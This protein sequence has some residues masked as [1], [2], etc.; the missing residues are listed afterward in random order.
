MTDDEWYEKMSEYEEELSVKGRD[1]APPPGSPLP[2]VSMITEVDVSSAPMQSLSTSSLPSVSLKAG[3]DSSSHLHQSMRSPLPIKTQY[4]L[5]GTRASQNRLIVAVKDLETAV[6]KSTG[7]WELIPSSDLSLREASLLQ[8]F[9]KELQ[10]FTSL[11]SRLISWGLAQDDQ[12]VED[13]TEA[14]AICRTQ[15]LR[16][17]RFLEPIISNAEHLQK[18]ARR[19]RAGL[20]QLFSRQNFSDSFEVANH[21]TNSNFFDVAKGEDILK[22]LTHS[23]GVINGLL[24]RTRSISGS[25]SRPPEPFDALPDADFGEPFQVKWSSSMESGNEHEV[26]NLQPLENDFL[27]AIRMSDHNRMIALLENGINIDAKLSRDGNA[28]QIAARYGDL[29]VVQVLLDHKANVNTDVGLHGPPLQAAVISRDESVVRLLLSHGARVNTQG[30][31][32]GSALRAAAN[33]N[34]V[35]I[36]RLLLDHGAYISFADRQYFKRLRDARSN[37]LSGSQRSELDNLL[38]AHETQEQPGPTATDFIAVPRHSLQK[39]ATKSPSK[40]WNEYEDQAE[41]VYPCKGC[42]EIV[43]NHRTHPNTSKQGT[44][45]T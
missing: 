25:S 6:K 36:A 43:S 22:Q 9:S 19:Q 41:I 17:Q 7:R 5:S 30:G 35:S 38:L 42:G 16:L 13:A 31:D 37:I 34:L 2:C 4:P 39:T 28:L 3:E 33:L 32:Y 27:S 12:S 40:P 20:R 15:L 29:Q 26:P 24:T 1:S 14:L 18:K 45:L 21:L 44:W 8:S 11:P 10:R 23:R